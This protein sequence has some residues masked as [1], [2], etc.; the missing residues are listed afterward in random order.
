[1]TAFPNSKRARPA[2]SSSS[3]PPAL[4]TST[5]FITTQAT[6][7]T[8]GLDD[9]IVH[10]AL[11]HAFLGELLWRFAGPEGQVKR[12]QCSYRGMDPAAQGRE[13]AQEKKFTLR[14]TVTRKYTEGERNIVELNIEGVRADGSV[15]TPGNGVVILPSR[16]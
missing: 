5:R 10:G 4:A 14:G 11:K 12:V 1:M 6:R 3:G 15:S 2:S 13:T 8:Q 16:G 9:I 7:R